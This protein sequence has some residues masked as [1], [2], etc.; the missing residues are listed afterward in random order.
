MKINRE[1][2]KMANKLYGRKNLETKING[3]FGYV[4]E[5]YFVNRPNHK[6]SSL[7]ECYLKCSKAK[8]EIY[9]DCVNEA[10]AFNAHDFG[11]VLFNTLTFT[12]AYD[13]IYSIMDKEGRK[14]KYIATCLITPN[15]KTI[16]LEESDIL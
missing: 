1:S 8:E 7:W 5:I 10:V 15:K 16:W 13:F 2:I 6:K 9:C 3:D 4:N 14:H 11:V 12:F